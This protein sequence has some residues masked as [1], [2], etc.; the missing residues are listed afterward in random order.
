MKKPLLSLLTA[1]AFST[2]AFASDADIAGSNGTPRP[3]S[4]GT[5]NPH[6]V[7]PSHRENGTISPSLRRVKFSVPDVSH[8]QEVNEKSTLEKIADTYHAARSASAKAYV[9]ADAYAAAVAEADAALDAASADTDAYAAAE[10]ADTDVSNSRVKAFFSVTDFR[11]KEAAAK[12]FSEAESQTKAAARSAI[13][14][15][16]SLINN[17]S[18]ETEATAKSAG[19][20]NVD[21]FIKSIFNH[22][23]VIANVDDKAKIA[24]NKA[25]SDAKTQ[26]NFVGAVAEN[27]YAVFLAA[28]DEAAATYAKVALDEAY[29]NVSK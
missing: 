26:A 3:P 23:A 10:L 13:A 6:P 2:P 17:N 19:F 7:N 4:S 1:V 8:R 14:D 28:L 12:A 16:K 24:F 21:A 25:V 20:A 18:A 5:A 29:K 11:A 22:P 9:A 27:G 15:F